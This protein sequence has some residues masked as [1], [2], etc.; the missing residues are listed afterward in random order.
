MPFFTPCCQF[1]FNPM[2]A[3]GNCI[4]NCLGRIVCNSVWQNM[5]PPV[6]YG[7]PNFNFSFGYNN[8]YP[9]S[10]PSYN[11]MPSFPT[12][13]FP[14]F[15]WFNNV[16]NFNFWNNAGGVNY[17]TWANNTT[18]SKSVTSTDSFEK[19]TPQGLESYNSEKGMRVAQDA[20]AHSPN[21]FTDFCARHVYNALERTGLNTNMRRQSGYGLTYEF[22]KNPNFR[23]VKV[24]SI[25]WQ[26]LPA[27]CILLYKPGSQG[28]SDKWGHV[29]ITV[30]DGTAVSDGITQNIKKPDTI[31]IP[32]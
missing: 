27:G 30:G 22:R 4:G 2:F 5:N 12:W 11:F 10:F 7:F 23:E 19:S 16:G 20:L 32:V 8:Y 18:L 28:Y 9:M 21:K 6:N 31:F 14:S 25:D 15:N 13:E 29:E 3:L 24:E 17:T 26:N 1:N